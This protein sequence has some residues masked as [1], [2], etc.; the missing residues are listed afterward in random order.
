MIVHLFTILTYIYTPFY[1]S[2][3]NKNRN[4]D[5]KGLRFFLL[6]V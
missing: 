5:T 1:F 2:F 3:A 6:V 4:F